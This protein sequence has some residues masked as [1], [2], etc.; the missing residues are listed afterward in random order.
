M[1][2]SK[3]SKAAAAFLLALDATLTQHFDRRILR[4]Q[5]S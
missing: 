3:L 2:R 4:I 5:R 1:F